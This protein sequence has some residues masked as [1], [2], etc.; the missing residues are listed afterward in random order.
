MKG[1][2][3]SSKQARSLVQRDVPITIGKAPWEQDEEP[4]PDRKEITPADTTKA[5]T[6]WG[7]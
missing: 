6:D 4:Q 5:A 1:E 3:V 2:T 7:Y